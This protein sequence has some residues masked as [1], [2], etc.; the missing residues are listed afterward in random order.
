MKSERFA[1]VVGGPVDAQSEV[2]AQ[3]TQFENGSHLL[4]SNYNSTNS[5]KLKEPCRWVEA[6]LMRMWRY[7]TVHEPQI[8][9][10]GISLTLNY[11][12]NGKTRTFVP[13]HN[14]VN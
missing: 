14:W 1:P 13:D 9:S 8:Q 2:K 5:R 6:Q 12:R 11:R 4:N 10:R 7:S 3:Q